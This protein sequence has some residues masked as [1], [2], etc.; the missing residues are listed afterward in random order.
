MGVGLAIYG[1]VT[2]YK[3]LLKKPK[4]NRVNFKDV[5]DFIQ[6]FMNWAASHLAAG[7]EL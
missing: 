2:S 7:K 4:F 3:L 1:G 6:P 5:I